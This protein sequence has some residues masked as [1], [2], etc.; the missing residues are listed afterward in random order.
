MLWYDALDVWLLNDNAMTFAQ[1]GVQFGFFSVHSQ[2]LS[3]CFQ[4]LWDPQH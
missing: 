2:T 3:L 4:A 1:F